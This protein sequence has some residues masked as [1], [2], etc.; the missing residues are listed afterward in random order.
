[1]PFTPY[2]FGPSGL[3]GL[4]LRKWIDVPVF[5]LVNIAVDIEVLLYN[6]WPYHRYTHT[7][8]LGAALGLV[9]GAIAYFARPLLIKAMR[10]VRVRYKPNLI[11]MIIS[12][13]LGVWLHV[14]IDAIYHY[15]VLVFWPKKARPFWRLLTKPEVEL[16]CLLSFIGV[17]VL[18]FF[19]VRS[20]NKRK[21]PSN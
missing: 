18:Y 17:A 20:F 19:A 15:D 7:F 3:I 13:I 12:G 5:M 2:H 10:L 1:M 14:F 4:A 16:W 21:T 8:L 9:C 6:R 11:K